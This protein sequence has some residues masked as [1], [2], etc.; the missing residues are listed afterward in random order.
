MNF[1]SCQ[2]GYLVA[3]GIKSLLVFVVIFGLMSHASIASAQV[4]Q[5]SASVDRNSIL[6]DESMQL[7]LVAVGSASRDA[8]DFSA[9]QTN[10]RI[11]QPSFSQSTQIINGSMSRSV[12]WVVNLYPKQTGSFIIPSFS[13]DGQSSNEFSI[14]VLPIDTATADQPREFYVTANIDNQKIYL[15]QQILYTVKIHLSR[16]IV[17]GQLTQPELS[18]A[19]IEQIGEDQDYQEIIDGVRYR[20]IERKYAIIPQSSGTFTITGP[21]FEAEVE[22][23]SRRSFANF[24][25]RET[26]A[27]RAPN[28]DINVLPIPDS[29]SD[30][31]L[32][33]ELVELTEQWQGNIEPL[34]VG[35]P[36]TRTI[37][38]TALGLTKEQLPTLSLPYHPSFKVYPEQPTLATA[39]HNNK[40]IAQG[41]F[42]SAII[43]EEAGSFVM[44]EVRIPWFNVNTGQTEVAVLPA[45]SIKVIA[46][47][48]GTSATLQNQVSEVPLSPLSPLS[49]ISPNTQRSGEIAA[50]IWSLNWL[51]YALIASNVFSLLAFY[52]YF[53]MG[54]PTRKSLKPIS[55]APSQSILSEEAAYKRVKTLLEQGKV[56][57]LHQALAIWLQQLF[58]QQYYSVSASLATYPQTHAL[59]A[60]NKTLARGFSDAPQDIDYQYLIECFS[61]FRSLANANKTQRPLASLYPR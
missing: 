24:G 8:V 39:E 42:N 48:A 41:V 21:I 38:L 28:I 17:R 45:R 52:V 33:S 23:N 4:T 1:K 20:I 30:T 16:D 7:S 9:L 35:E 40:L 31:W 25:R 61:E 11:S 12:T 14:R 19:I 5:L 60:Y 56:D 53:L 10:F 51:H 50:S 15:Q 47:P 27:R 29:Y 55:S 43:P 13:I 59:E 58:A 18:G 54:K 34:T 36:V 6:L 3:T 49:P 22:T 44:P 37:T 26:I 57:G 2:P 32:P 46:K